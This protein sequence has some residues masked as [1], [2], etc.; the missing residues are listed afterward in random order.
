MHIILYLSV[1]SWA[2]SCSLHVLPIACASEKTLNLSC[3]SPVTSASKTKV[4]SCIAAM[5]SHGACCLLLQHTSHAII[6]NLMPAVI[7][8]E[9]NYEVCCL[10]F[11]GCLSDCIKLPQM[12]CLLLAVGGL[13]D[14]RWLRSH[15]LD[16]K[17]MS[18]VVACYYRTTWLWLI[19]PRS[20]R[21]QVWTQLSL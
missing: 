13:L 20:T 9:A 12:C 8:H 10:L 2:T 1:F 5:Q 15:L 14:V 3:L 17:L 11:Q 7:A 6:Q 18:N 21:C 16:V 4:C 19:V